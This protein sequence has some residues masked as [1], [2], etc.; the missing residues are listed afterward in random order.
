MQIIWHGTASIEIRNSFGRLLFDPFVPLEGAETNT[1]IET[2]DGFSDILVTH[3]HF[4]HIMNLPEI[5]VRN[6]EV[7]IYCTKTP[8]ETLRRKGVETR[9]LVLITYGEV[10]DIRGFHITAYHGRHAVLNIASR[11]ARMPVSQYRGNMPQIIRETRVCREND[12]TLFYHIECEGR[13]ISVMGS[14]NLREDVEYPTGADALVLPYN[15]WKDNLQPAAKAI[16]RLKP[17]RVLLDHYDDTFPPA[18]SKVDLTGILDRYDNVSA[19][20]TEEA[21]EV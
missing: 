7:R 4:D 9:N 2:Y 17:K 15:G 19:L 6:P 16:E 12:E 5:A 18:T 10:L 11:A 3:G 1:P 20:K 21:V 8:Y 14:L 13:Y